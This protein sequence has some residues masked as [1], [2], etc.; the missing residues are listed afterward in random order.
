MIDDRVLIIERV[1]PATREAL[2]DAFADPAQMV[3]WWGPEGSVVRDS[4]F[5]LAIGGAWHTLLHHRDGEEHHV[6]G[7]YVTVEAPSRLAFTWAW[8]QADGRR[9]HQTLVDLAFSSDPAGARLTL[10]QSL[11]PSPEHRDNHRRGWTS[12]FADLARFL[13]GRDAA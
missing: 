5:D 11:F 1:F 4:A 7:V 3:Q 8:R 12:S 10:R 2:F 9:G 13:S 6:S